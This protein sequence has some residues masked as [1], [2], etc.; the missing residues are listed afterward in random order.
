MTQSIPMNEL[1]SNVRT[2]LGVPYTDK[3]SNSTRSGVQRPASR[4]AV[5][6]KASASGIVP[7]VTERDAL[8]TEEAR[9][10]A[11]DVRKAQS[12][13]GAAMT[14]HPLPGASDI[15]LVGR[16]RQGAKPQA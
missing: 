7:A 15:K 2:R 9:L 14:T 5:I 4:P 1:S 16:T 10:L 11:V 6:S 3:K 13:D 8:Q 12:G